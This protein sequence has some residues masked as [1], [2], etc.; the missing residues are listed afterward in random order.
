MF[1]A[2]I[3][4]CHIRGIP[5]IMSYRLV[6]YLELSWRRTVPQPERESID[7]QL[8]VA[9]TLVGVGAEIDGTRPSRV[10]L[11]HIVVEERVNRGAGEARSRQLLSADQTCRYR[12]AGGR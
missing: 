9:D 5:I 7:T 4:Q 10:Q 8:D 6:V 2:I 1:Y 12:S 3:V 11:E